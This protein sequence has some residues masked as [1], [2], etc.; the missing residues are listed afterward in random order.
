MNQKISVEVILYETIILLFGMLIIN[1]SLGYV[2]RYLG[3]FSVL[4]IS[5]QLIGLVNIAM[6]TTIAILLAVLVF[7]FLNKITPSQSIPIFRFVGYTALLLSLIIPLIIPAINSPTIIMFIIIHLITGIAI[8]ER[9][10]ILTNNSYKALTF[11]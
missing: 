1:L 2:F 11:K 4:R 5:D 3:W 7:S 8:I 9:L 10:S 6:G